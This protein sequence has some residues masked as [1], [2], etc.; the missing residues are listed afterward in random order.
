MPPAYFNNCL[1]VSL[2]RLSGNSI[3]FKMD[4]E[5]TIKFRFRLTDDLMYFELYQIKIKLHCTVALIETNTAY[6][7]S[8][9]AGKKKSF[10]L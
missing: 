8:H 10:T 2:W 3:A 5:K 6:M 9:A 4:F 1:S 7:A